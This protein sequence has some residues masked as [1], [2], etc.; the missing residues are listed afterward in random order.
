VREAVC[1]FVIAAN[2]ATTPQRALQIRDLI[3]ALMVELGAAEMIALDRADR[4]CGLTA[5]KDS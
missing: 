3:D 1:D 5:R 4:L 2:E